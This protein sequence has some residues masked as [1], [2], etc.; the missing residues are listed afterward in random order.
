MGTDPFRIGPQCEGASEEIGKMALKGFSLGVAS[1][2]IG[3]FDVL[4]ESVYQAGRRLFGGE[5]DK[6][7]KEIKDAYKEPDFV[8]EP[9]GLS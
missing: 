4:A 2:A 5:R 7:L 8:T 3:L 6:I 1:K 9:V